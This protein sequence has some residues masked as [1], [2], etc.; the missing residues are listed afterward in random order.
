MQDLDS[1][2]CWLRRILEIRRSHPV[3]SLGNFEIL[4]AQNTAIMAFIR[5]HNEEILVCIN[6]FSDADQIANLNLQLYDGMFL[7]DIL[8]DLLL[9]ASAGLRYNAILPPYGF[10]WLQLKKR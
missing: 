10:A 3:L 5:K 9:P 7:Y 1:F 2:L 4:D 6:N 8:E